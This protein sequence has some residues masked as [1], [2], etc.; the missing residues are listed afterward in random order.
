MPVR[1][2]GGTMASN[3]SS[4]VV[5]NV[6]YVACQWAVLALLTRQLSAAEVGRFALAVAI[7]APVFIIA[8]LR[9]RSV[10]VSGIGSANGLSDFVLL[11]LATSVVAVLA[12]L[13]IGTIGHLSGRDLIILGLVA[14]GKAID[15]ISDIC[16]GFFQ[17]LLRLRASAVGLT[18]NGIASVCLVAGTLKAFARVEYATLAYA[19]GSLVAL[20]LWNIPLALR[21]ASTNQL[22]FSAPVNRQRTPR[23]LRLWKL[24]LKSAP[25]G[26]SS[27]VGSLH[28]NF[29]QYVIAA[30]LGPAPLAAF[31]AL[32]YLPAAGNVLTNAVSQA[33]LPVLV[34]DFGNDRTQ[35]RHHLLRWVVFGALLGVVG[36]TIAA[37]WGSGIIALVYTLDYVPY[38]DLL[39]WLTAATAV[40]YGYV[41]LGTGA[42]A[43]HR[44]GAQL[45]ISLLGF[46]ALIVLAPIL[47]S[48]SGV[49][50]A[51]HALLAAAVLQALGYV[52]LTAWDLR[53]PHTSQTVT[54]TG[55]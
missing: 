45:A 9:L 24:T 41:F 15:S 47:V 38:S 30:M 33:I 31:A 19:S 51:A 27:A 21:L 50:G 2:A 28:A 13:L 32:A 3:I 8:D 49:N 26:V 11:R 20:L 18:I 4:A 48:N 16:H 5:G 37:V 6:I 7:S 17:S 34:R 1:E 10:L 29:P 22:P 53:V 23:L 25:L 43:R 40:S 54:V 39:F 36:T 52:L 12:T 55:V 35:Y 44:F 14:A 46:S 42:V